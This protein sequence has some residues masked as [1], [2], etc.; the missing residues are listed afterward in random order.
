MNRR[1]HLFIDGFNFYH[2]IMDPPALRRYRWLNFRQLGEALLP[3]AET[4]TRVFYF[5]AFYPGDAAKR[6]RHQAFIDAQKA[7][8]VETVLGAFRRRDRYCRSCQRSFPGYEEKETDVN[9]VITLFQGA[10][11]DEYDK[12]VIVS[13]DSDLVPAIRAVKASFP[14]KQLEVVFPPGRGS[15][16]LKAHADR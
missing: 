5:T 1:V 15:K 10:I 16:H 4:L 11:N 9:I 2:A 7:F 3:R 14:Q 13:G 8:H 6:Q 12:A